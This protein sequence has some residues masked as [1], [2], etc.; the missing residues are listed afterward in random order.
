MLDNSAVIFLTWC[1]L[2]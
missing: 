1:K 2:P